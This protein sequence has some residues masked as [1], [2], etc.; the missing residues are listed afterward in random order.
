MSLRAWNNDHMEHYEYDDSPQCYEEFEKEFETAWLNSQEIPYSVIASKQADDLIEGNAI[1][2]GIK[3]T[4]KAVIL[5]EPEEIES[6]EVIKYCIDHEKI[7][8]E[9][10][11]LLDGVSVKNKEGFI[12]IAPD[13]IEKI[14]HNHKKLLQKHF[15]QI[16]GMKFRN[17]SGL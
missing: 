8:E 7:K 2:K 16:M 15:L 11:A 3:E 13:T 4:E 17:I 5:Q 1:V 6:F 14:V 10:K 9:Y 12:K